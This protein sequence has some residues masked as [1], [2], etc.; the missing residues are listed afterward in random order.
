MRLAV[1]APRDEDVVAAYL[2]D[3]RAA[4]MRSSEHE[5]V[6]GARVFFARLGGI[7]GW[8]A[9]PLVD[10]LAQNVKVHR[11]V[12]WLAATQRI[13]IDADYLT[14]RRVHLGTVLPR[15]WPEFHAG[16]VETARTLGFGAASI[17][18]QWSAL[19][20]ACAV[21]GV[22][23]SELTHARL[24]DA[25]R[26]LVDAARR[27]GRTGRHLSSAMHGL[28]A[29]LFHAGVSD[30]LPR[31]RAPSKESARAAEWATVPETM[32]ATMHRYLAQ[33]EVSLRPGTVKRHE[34]VL[35]Q[36]ARFVA[37]QDPCVERVAAVERRHVEAYKLWLIERPAQR[38]PRLHRHTIREQLGVLR[39]LFVRLIEWDDPDAPARVMIVSADLPIPDE[40]LPR[41]LDDAAAAKLMQA[42]RADDDQFVRLCVEFLARTGLRRSEFLA[43]TVDA[44]VQIGSAYW[45]RVPVGKLH[46]DRYIPLH[47]TLKNLLDD[48]LARRPAD[49]RSNLIFVDHGRPIPA[50]RVERA[51]AKTA[52]SAGVGRV[53]PHQ[54][55]HTLATQA[56]NRGMS[57]EA[58]AALLGHRSLSMTLVYARIAD[59]SVADEYF[60]V[61]EKVEAL[62]DRPRELPAGAEGREMRKLRAEVDRRMLGNGWC[63]RPIE[64]DCHFETV[65]ESCSF[66]VTT[67]EFKPTLRRQLDDAAAK[68]QV[69]RQ[70]L[71]E[72][73]LERLDQDEAS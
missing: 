65:C 15:H 17:T 59:R 56:I 39:S 27:Q 67:V 12:T 7:D 38:G 53:T 10:R 73:L 44:V 8:Q 34:S 66:F 5:L 70:H 68:G 42:A 25:H 41:F 11:F 43:L 60:T 63:T 45:L 46:N 33:L 18:R 54:L 3:L 4:G 29:T 55:R 58:I 31:K 26:R 32:A 19:G 71:F 52:A 49:L 2:A 20:Q 64:M 57:L 40:P 23:P 28:Q 24:D 30:E 9:M 6:W 1:V 21:L 69:A 62:Y 37:L 16:F 22:A 61:T 72:G 13:V 14:A 47:P 51:V 35:R 48:W 50:S 36:F